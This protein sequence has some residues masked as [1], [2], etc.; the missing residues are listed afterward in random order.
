M[1]IILI[2]TAF[3]LLTHSAAL[4]QNSPEELRKI[5]RNPFADEIELSFENQ[6]TFDQGRYDRVANF[7]GI[8]PRFPL[9]ISRV[10]SRF[11]ALPVT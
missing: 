10:N 1:R 7:L 5:A 8:Q 3:L 2:G 9:S 11:V 4:A 6:V